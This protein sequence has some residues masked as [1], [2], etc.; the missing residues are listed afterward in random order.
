MGLKKLIKN[1]K[2]LM[3]N[4]LNQKPNYLEIV[5]PIA[6]QMMDNLK[7]EL[8]EDLNDV[9]IPEIK[10]PEETIDELINTTK[11]LARF[12]DG[13]FQIING[14]NC[15]FD[16][17]NKKFS[18]KLK[19][20][21]VA[22]PP[23]LMVGIPY[24]YYHS[25]KD[26]SETDIPIARWYYPFCRKILEKYIDKSKV[27]Y[28]N[29]IS[30]MYIIG[31]KDNYDEYFE[32]AK[33]IWKDKDI[34]IVC[35][36]KVFSHIETNIFDC[37]KSIEYIYTPTVNASEKYDGILE[38]IKKV[39]SKLILLICGPVATALAYDICN[40]NKGIQA[41]DIGHL[42]KDYDYYIHR[43]SR[44]IDSTVLFFGRKE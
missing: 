41:I 20:I 30:Q 43:R 8:I 32:K 28:S 1:I 12:G 14:E 3:R 26:K 22:P 27:Y 39:N 35:G 34:T 36:E 11:S 7:Y 40:L 5:R 44:Q 19:E 38:E 10:T 37:A 31:N 24:C 18:Q 25:F 23:D 29:E 16:K 33:Q 21:L 4:D 17:P 6:S 42:A 15:I 2:F 13:E 9:V